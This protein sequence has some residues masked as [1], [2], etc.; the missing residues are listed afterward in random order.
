MQIGKRGKY[1]GKGRG[2]A[3]NGKEERGGIDLHPGTADTAPQANVTSN[4]IFQKAHNCQGQP[5]ATLERNVRI[6]TSTAPLCQ[7]AP[8][9][10][11]N[12]N[13]EKGLTDAK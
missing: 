4:H 2:G 6:P 8:I 3:G 13:V 7:L 11:S 5:K 1:W 9:H 12:K 10:K